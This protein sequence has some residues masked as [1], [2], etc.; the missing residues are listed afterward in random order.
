LI[1]VGVVALGDWRLQNNVINPEGWYLGTHTSALTFMVFG[2]VIFRRQVKAIE[3]V[4]QLGQR[5][6]TISSWPST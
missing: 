4:R 2:S 3:E 6:W 5:A 1:A